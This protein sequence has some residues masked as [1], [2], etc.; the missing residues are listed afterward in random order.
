[1][2]QP[3]NIAHMARRIASCLLIAALALTASTAH[4]TL[5]NLWRYGHQTYVNKFVSFVYSDLD[6]V[7]SPDE[8]ICDGNPFMADYILVSKERQTLSVIDIFGRTICC[9]PA[10]VGINYGDKVY[11][12]DLRTPEGELFVHEILDASLWGNDTN[13]GN[14]YVQGSYGN[15]FIRLYAPPHYGI[16]I[17]ATLRRHNLGTRASEGCICLASEDLDK[18]QPL[19]R[20]YMKVIVEPSIRDMAA[21][22]RC[23]ILYKRYDSEYC[24]FEPMR[25]SGELQCDVVQDRVVHTVERGDTHLSLAVKYGTSRKAIEALNYAVDLKHLTPGQKIVVRGSF[26]VLLDGVLRWGENK[27]NTGPEYYIATPIDTFGR[28]A[29]MH[30]THATVIQRLNPDITPETLEPG[31]SIRVR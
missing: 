8:E 11:P 26:S 10:T 30:G 5:R 9:F 18:L 2:S 28:I 22:G 6:I 23:F 25:Y 3:Q 21:D 12:G 31:M 15:W 29:V 7:D 4:A 13:D 20:E 14:G 1:M 24:M 27:E 16:G 17:H 19:V